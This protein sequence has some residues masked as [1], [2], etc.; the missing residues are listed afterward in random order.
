K[1]SVAVSGLKRATVYHFRIVASNSGGTTMGSD[2]TFSTSLAPAVQTG[3][4]QG[5]SVGGATL[6]GSV[7]PKGRSTKRWFEH[8]PITSYGSKT[9]TKAAGSASGPQSVSAAVAGLK[10]ATAYH[11]RLVATSDAG[12]TA[13]AD[14]TFSTLGVTLTASA[15]EVVF[16]GRVRLQG[17][18]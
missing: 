7:D 16:G 2:R 14:Q 18:V 5:I 4:A 10:P 6:T 3:A 12:T 8:G 13:G 15:R 9:A 1:V 11:F 17:T